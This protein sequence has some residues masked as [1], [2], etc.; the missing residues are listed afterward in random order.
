[1][2]PIVALLLAATLVPTAAA[3]Q[4]PAPVPRELWR[5][6]PLD[7]ARTG[8]TPTSEAP[9]ARARPTPASSEDAGEDT[10]LLGLA[11]VALATVLAVALATGV[12]AGVRGRSRSR[13]A[14][15]PSTPAPRSTDSGDS[16]RRS[17]PPTEQLD[18][19][20]PLKSKRAAD[21]RAA[22]TSASSF[23]DVAAL[24]AKLFDPAAGGKEAA[25]TN[26][27]LEILKSKR[28]ADASASK[29]N[30]KRL[31]GVDTLKTKL[32]RVGMTKVEAP[33]RQAID[34]LGTKLPDRQDG[35]DMPRREQKV[36]RAK[37]DLVPSRPAPAPP[38][39]NRSPRRSRGAAAVAPVPLQLAERT[40]PGD[41]RSLVRCYVRLWRGYVKAQFYAIEPS[42]TRARRVIAESPLFWKRG[43]EPPT[44]HGAPA[45]AHA[46]LIADLE[47]DGWRVVARGS[48]WFHV[49][50]ERAEPPPSTRKTQS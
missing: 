19:L 29:P 28:E 44:K 43:G 20:E 49:Q 35:P 11:A 8:R 2:P 30:G 12:L 7:D 45:S 5:Q 26:D 14:R 37:P 18:E 42:A 33:E 41:S 50:L 27:D 46:A 4:E 32:D 9:P 40:E 23:D 25:P 17:D 13:P 16:A 15:G 31:G 39:P 38:P 3:Q 48:Q 24:K 47:R 36:P 1:M 6:F 21:R 10:R 34:R 22:K